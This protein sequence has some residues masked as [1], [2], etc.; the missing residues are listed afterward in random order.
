M[1]DFCPNIGEYH[2]FTG[3]LRSSK[4][5]KFTKCSAD[6]DLHDINE[7]IKKNILQKEPDGGRSTN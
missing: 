2:S 7:L 3:K 5:A 6:T 4:W 1:L